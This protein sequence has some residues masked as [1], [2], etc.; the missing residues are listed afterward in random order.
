MLV[1]CAYEIVGGVGCFFVYVRISDSVC[2]KVEPWLG[3]LKMFSFRRVYGS[4][5]KIKET[6]LPQL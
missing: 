1:T 3:A 5:E 6:Q 2:T 4:K